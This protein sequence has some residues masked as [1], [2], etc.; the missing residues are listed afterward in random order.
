MKYHIGQIVEATVTG[1]QPY[2]AFL[3]VDSEF[4]G[5]VHISELSEGFVRDV[6]LF[7]NVGDKLKLKVLDVDE[8][9]RQLRLSLKAL[10]QPSLRKERKHMGSASRLPANKIGFGSLAQKLEEW[11]QQAKKELNHD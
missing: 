11:I 1:I 9:N 8:K 10:S 5:L 7:M 3:S 4:T 6:A 2:G